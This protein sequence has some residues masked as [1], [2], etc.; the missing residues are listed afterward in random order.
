MGRKILFVLM[1]ISVGLSGCDRLS[2]KDKMEMIAKCDI[3][4]RKKFKEEEDFSEYGYI[5]VTVT[6]NFSFS[7]NRCYTLVQTH[8]TPSEFVRQ[9]LSFAKDETIKVLYDGLTKKELIYVSTSGTV[10]GE[11]VA[12]GATVEQGSNLIDVHMNRP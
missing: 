10:T 5:K 4:A 1:G 12:T 7:D 8:L 2:E 6:T 3:E 11:N 9:K